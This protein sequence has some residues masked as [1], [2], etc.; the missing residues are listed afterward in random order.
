MRRLSLL[1]IVVIV[2]GVVAAAYT[3]RVTQVR[4]TGLRT[5]QAAEVIR[6]SGVEVGQRILWIR[7]SSAA[8][9]V[10]Q[11]PAVERATA[12]RALPGTVVIHITER[13][14]VAKL[15]RTPDLVVD[16]TGR[17][18]EAHTRGLPVL[19]AWQIAGSK[20]D[21]DATSS[22]GLHAFE[23]L[24]AAIRDATRSIVLRPLLELEL[25][26]GVLIRFGHLEDLGAKA[27]AVLAVLRAE[28][29]HKIAYV[30]VQVPTVPV[31]GPP[32]TPT[33]APVVAPTPYVTLHH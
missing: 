10:E 9:S 17:V 16:R 30:D 15:S 12:S 23:G 22:A 13:R 3:L 2:G 19:D 24:P 27:A 1:L 14:P 8:H 5:L 31:V 4:V 28:A 20:H 26:T 6:S 25:R 29:G 11:I 7:L 33:P 18:F 21:L 32:P